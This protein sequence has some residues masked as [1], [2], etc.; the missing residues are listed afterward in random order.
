MLP[1]LYQKGTREL[2][3]QVLQTPP[4]P[5]PRKTIDEV[6]EL[7]LRLGMSLSLSLSSMRFSCLKLLLLGVNLGRK[8][9]T[10][11][12]GNILWY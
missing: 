3:L 8:T 4:S 2:I 9:E 5:P 10:M 7:G 11:E 6:T 12:S 1:T